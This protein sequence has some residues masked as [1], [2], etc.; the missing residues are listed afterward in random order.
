MN[1]DEKKTY[2]VKINKL[3]QNIIKNHDKFKKIIFYFNVSSNFDNQFINYVKQNEKMFSIFLAIRI[4][5]HTGCQ[6]SI[7]LNV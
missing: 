2:R 1:A 4:N 6:L 3:F 7:P 5:S